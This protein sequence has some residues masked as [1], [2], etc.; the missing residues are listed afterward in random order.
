MIKSIYMVSSASIHT[1]L[2][3]LARSGYH[4]SVSMR[5]N[6]KQL[7]ISLLVALNLS[8]WSSLEYINYVGFHNFSLFML[9]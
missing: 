2:I 8:K 9:L 4:N 5:K 1:V 7:G 3:H 6:I